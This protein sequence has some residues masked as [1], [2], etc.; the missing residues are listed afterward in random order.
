MT[1]DKTGF[2]KLLAN[3]TNFTLRRVVERLREGLFDPF[4]VQVLTAREQQLDKVF[5][6]GV[7]ALLKNKSAHLCVC[8]AYGQGKSHT[9]SYLKERALKQGFVTSLINLDP[10]EI[11][12]HNFRRTYRALVS[13]IVFP[14]GSPSLVKMW[15]DWAG[16]GYKTLLGNDLK[17]APAD[18]LSV[19]PQDMPHLFKA[20]LTALAN[21]NRPL[22]KRQRAFKKHAA[23]RPREF[24]WILANT[25]NGNAPPIYRLCHA[26][27]YRQVDFYKD[28][29]LVCKGWEPYFELVRTLAV[30][31]QKMGYKGWV[32]LFDEAE[33]TVQTPINVRRKNYRVLDRFFS[34]KNPM[35]GLYPIFALTD[36]FFGVVQNEDYDRVV[37]RRQKETRYFPKNYD[38]AWRRLNIHDLKGLA[39]QEW[40]TLAQK[41]IRFH[42][43][44]YGWQPPD[45]RLSEQLASVLTET[46]ADEPR[47]KIKALVNQLDF[48]HQEM[49]L[50]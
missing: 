23:F 47:L 30:M 37:M 28:N 15:R 42:A 38:H 10:R 19:I 50:D 20:T 8:G 27:K 18:P 45:N 22:S 9:L 44:A 46:A 35:G 33:S 11:P 5:D 3:T 12:L 40:Q 32:V 7:H 36:D 48:A 16:G 39:P 13:R 21:K 17:K 25:L 34:F 31:F 29:S 49:V 6:Q 26:L 4:G 14:D 1:M 41:L 43:K 24:P 2:T